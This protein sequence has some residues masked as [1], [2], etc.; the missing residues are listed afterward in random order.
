MRFKS[1]EVY[2]FKSFANKTVVHFEPGV[3]AIVGPNGCG[4]SNISDSIRWVLGEQSAKSLRGSSMEDVIFNGSSAK[5]AVNFAEVSLTLSNEAKLL[6]IDYEEVTL[7]RRLHRSGESEYLINKNPVRLKDIH[8]LLMGTGIGTE[9]YAIIEQGKM[10]VILNSKPDERRAIFEEAAGITKFKAKK[11]EALR[12]LEQTD[13]NLLRVNDII[14]EVK[15]QIG[16]IERQAKKAES[17]KAEFERMKKLELSV[18]SKEFLTFESRRQSKESELADLKEKEQDC[19]LSL[20][21]VEDACHAAREALAAVDD[22]LRASDAEAASAAADIRQ[23]QDRVLLNRERIGE[24]AERRENLSRQIETARRRVEEFRREHDNL[25]LEFDLTLKEEA[26]GQA[27]LASVETAFNQIENFITASLGEE[28]AAKA[29]LSELAEKKTQI[30]NDLARLNAELASLAARLRRLRDEEETVGGEFHRAEEAAAAAARVL[31]DEESRLASQSAQIEK[32][33]SRVAEVGASNAG[34][35][36]ALGAL[37]VEESALRSKL[38]FLEDL[39]QRHEGFLGGVKAL[40]DERS[41]NAHLGGMVGLLADALKVEKGFE[42]A[43][44]AALE[45]YLQAV[46]FRSSDDV[47]LAADFLRPLGKGRALLLSVDFSGGAAGTD[48]IAADSILNHVGTDGEAAVGD[49]LKK[50]VGNVYVVDD[51]RRAYELSRAHREAVFVTRSGERFEGELVMGGSLSSQADVALI[52]RDSRIRDAAEELERLKASII[53][54]TAALAAGRAEEET[55]KSAIESLKEDILSSQVSISDRRAKLS[56][57]EE[58]KNRLAGELDEIRREAA[59]LGAEEKSLID[60]EKSLNQDFFLLA[61]EDKRL[62][63]AVLGFRA[64]VREKAAEKEALLV[65]LAET[66]SKQSHCTAKREK[67]EKDKGWILQSISGEESQAA[68]YEKESEDA[69]NKKAALES[70]NASLETALAELSQ[71]RDEILRQVE[72]IRLERESTAARLAESEKT[73]E[74]KEAFLKTAL[75]RVHA[76]E[77]ENAQLRFEIDR[78]KERIYNAYQIDLAVQEGIAETNAGAGEAASGPV[79]V[80]A[81][82]AEIQ[83]IREKLNRMGP[84]NLVAIEEFDEMRQRYEFLTQ[85]EKDLIQAKDDLHKAIQKI[86]RTTRELFI[87]TFQ[88]VQKHFTEYY[89]LLFGGGSAEL[90]LLDQDDVLESGIEIVARPPGKKLQNISLLSGGEKALTAVSLLFSLFKVKPSPFCILDEIDAPLDETNVDRFCGV[91]KDFIGGSQFILITH[92]KRTMN[93]A[94]AMYGVTMAETGISKIVSVKF[95]DRAKTHANGNGA[96]LDKDRE[97]VLV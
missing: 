40:L 74:E 39:R 72:G 86:N 4:K 30:Q 31:S 78:L 17:Y 90:V 80:E 48:G 36:E 7:T 13:A 75:E 85:Q 65:K 18:A 49:V 59:Q 24:L 56:H 52:G 81:V 12:K 26:E 19:R 67:I 28:E 64:S 2:G 23:N 50:L 83:Q 38:E 35:E 79:D 95:S 11:K 10:D 14:Q 9:S 1:L 8:E 88:K 92:N 37:S 93:L 58:T 3:T 57:V 97:E 84:V 46:L 87:D 77:L 51:P 34:T 32:K 71:K 20:E 55:L 89:R 60:G 47:L 16:S 33:E 68:L 62:G 44:E 42:L 69:G 61:E 70:E 53:E 27:F 76:F 15:R 94:D 66:R 73:R 43:V 5:E 54:K 96:A 25:Q 63:E 91:L 82:K 45:S 21:A 22:S 6:P 41:S 29:K